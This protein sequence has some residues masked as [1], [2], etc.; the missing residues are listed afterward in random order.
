MSLRTV[1]TT[2][3]TFD[4]RME[5]VAH[6]LEERRSETRRE[7]DRLIART[8]AATIAELLAKLSARGYPMPAGVQQ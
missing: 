3:A 2:R 4:R 8:T 5:F 7:A 1:M 6:V